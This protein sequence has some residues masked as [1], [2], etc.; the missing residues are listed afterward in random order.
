MLE[1]KDH[2][3]YLSDEDVPTIQ[4][5]CGGVFIA[6]LQVPNAEA[7]VAAGISFRFGS[8][9]VGEHHENPF[10][11]GTEGENGAFFRI[12]ATKPESLQVLI[13]K[14]VI[15]RDSITPSQQF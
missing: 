3:V 13:D 2:R 1:A 6:D 9:E 12:I 11:G 4:M 5:G 7:P 8:G 15:A 10:P 14:L